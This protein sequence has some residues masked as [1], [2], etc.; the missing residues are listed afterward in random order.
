[1]LEIANPQ[2]ISAVILAG[3][4]LSRASLDQILVKARA[5]AAALPADTKN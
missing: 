4:F 5:A 3:N 2:K 1:L